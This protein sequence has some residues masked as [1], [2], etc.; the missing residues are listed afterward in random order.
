MQRYNFKIKI[1]ILFVFISLSLS[2]CASYV[3]NSEKPESGTVTAYKSRNEVLK[4]LNENYGQFKGISGRLAIS[5]KSDNFS[6]EQTGLYKYIRGRYM[7]FTIFD[8]YGDALFY[9]KIFKV[10]NKTVKAV[11]FDAGHGKLKS[12]DFDKEYTGK[13]LMYKRLFK[14]FKIFL[15][16]NSLDKIKKAG[17]FYNT[18]EGF[19]FDYRNKNKKRESYYIYVNKKYLIDKITAVRHKKITEIAYFKDYIL[20]GGSMVPLKIYVDDYLYNVKIKVA[21]S[22]GSKIIQ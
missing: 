12:V 20:K 14:V 6:F 4:G 21:L 5:A 16:L 18:R 8:M 22:K 1:L 7:Q 13:M 17:L 3:K 15:N 10:P 2:G 9:I 11:F 19:F